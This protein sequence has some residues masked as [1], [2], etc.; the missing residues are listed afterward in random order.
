[1][2]KII[3]RSRKELATGKGKTLLRKWWMS[4]GVYLKE[5]RI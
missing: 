3:R 5:K 1:M 2:N 4:V